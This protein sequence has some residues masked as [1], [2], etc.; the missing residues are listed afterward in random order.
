MPPSQACFGLLLPLC[1]SLRLLTHAHFAPSTAT[2]DTLA[3]AAWGRPSTAGP[4]TTFK[5]VLLGA[6]FVGK[7]CIS[8]RYCRGWTNLNELPTVGASFYAKNLE[9]NGTPI[10]FEVRSKTG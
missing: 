10:K 3:P 4:K 6:H 5:L 7:T 8:L 9:F 2:Q 1:A